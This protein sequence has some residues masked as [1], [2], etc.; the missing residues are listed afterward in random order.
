MWWR[1]NRVLDAQTGLSSIVVTVQKQ[2]PL[3]ARELRP[4]VKKKQ[5]VSHKTDP[6]FIPYF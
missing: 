6:V 3:H 5:Y 2:R 4:I 1:V